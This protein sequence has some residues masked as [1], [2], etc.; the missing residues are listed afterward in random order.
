MEWVSWISDLKKPNKS[1]KNLKARKKV[2][3]GLVCIAMLN[4]LIVAL[5]TEE[6]VLVLKHQP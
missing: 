5:K 1:T 3:R 2:R 6:T 4:S